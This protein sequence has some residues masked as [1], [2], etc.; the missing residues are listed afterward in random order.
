MAI[1]ASEGVGKCIA[2][3]VK[4]WKFPKPTGGGVVVVAHPFVLAPSWSEPPIL[5]CVSRPSGL[6]VALVLTGCGANEPAPV[7]K[8]PEE[9]AT[10]W[11]DVATPEVNPDVGSTAP[12][13]EPKLDVPPPA[14]ALANDGQSVPQVPAALPAVPPDAVVIHITTSDVRLGAVSVDVAAGSLP[15][16]K[17]LA[18]IV[19]AI[20]ESDGT[21]LIVPDAAVSAGVVRRVLGQIPADRQRALVARAA[22]GSEGLLPLSSTATPGAPEVTIAADGF[23]LAEKAGADQLHLKPVEG[24]DP[25]DYV[26]LRNKAKAFRTLHPDI[27]SVRIGSEPDVSAEVL[28]RALSQIRGP[29]CTPD[30][31][32]CWLPTMAF[33]ENIRTAPPGQEPPTRKIEFP[34][35]GGDDKSPGTVAVGKAKVP[36]TLD[37]EEVQQALDRRAGYARMCYFAALADEPTLEGTITLRLTVD[38]KGEVEEVGSPRATMKSIAVEDCLERGAKGLR[39][40]PPSDAPAMVDVTLTFERK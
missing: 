17:A 27:D 6:A 3:A 38:G 18:P 28:L 35:A 29:Q 31:G 40:T 25:F 2:K 34:K 20:S 37:K 9:E 30:P 15:N 10:T 32:R 26:A 11:G 22:D 21:V 16:E 39:F 24:G 36:D 19:A 33:G 14:P 5:R 7:A 12:L 4:R 8:A 13:A 23:H 1:V